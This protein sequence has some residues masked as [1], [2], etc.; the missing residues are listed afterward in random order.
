MVCRNTYNNIGGE[1]ILRPF[2]MCNLTEVIVRSDD[3]IESLERKARLAT[4]LGTIQATLTDFPY[5]RPIWK[6]NT[7]E[8]AL[9]GVSLT[10]IMDCQLL[11]VHPESVLPVLKQVAI[12]TNKEWA[13]LLGINPSTAITC[14]KPSGTVSQLTNSASGIHPRHSAYYIRSVRADNKDPLTQLMKESGIPNEPDR[15]KPDNTTVFYF[16]IKSPDSVTREGL[17]A[18]QHFFIWKHFKDHWCE[19]N[20]SITINIREDEWLQMASV[21]YENFN[22]IAG[23]AFL[24]YDDHVYAQAPYQECTEEEYNNLK[25]K[26]P[27]SID[28]ELLQQYEVEDTTIGMQTMA[29]S[30]DVCEIVDL[31]R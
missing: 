10:G 3:T 13:E 7:E 11:W 14:V 5:L 22:D 30:G 12:D 17:S 19:H 2:Q 26:M 1:I 18:V 29:C 20:P 16:P 4:I 31:I 23:V 28:W 6:K 27:K 25:S 8:E 15:M 9:L 24:P 21:V